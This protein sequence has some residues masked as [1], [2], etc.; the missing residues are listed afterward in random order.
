ML[1]FMSLFA[2]ASITTVP[3]D[4][5]TAPQA[6]VWVQQTTSGWSVFS[7]VEVPVDRGCGDL[8]DLEEV[9][10]NGEPAADLSPGR[11]LDGAC[12]APQARADLAPFE[13]EL[14]VEWVAG[15]ATRTLAVE[16]ATGPTNLRLSS[17]ENGIIDA[18]QDIVLS[19]DSPP[20]ME[21]IRVIAQ[22]PDGTVHMF[23]GDSQGT[24]FVISDHPIKGELGR[25]ELNRRD[26]TPAITEC[27][28]DW[29][30][31][32]WDAVWDGPMAIAL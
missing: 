32:L 10:F 29:D 3:L 15:G 13:G 21:A 2:C 11:K 12:E 8:S 24:D 30:C 18:E 7:D 22:G 28:E 27:P 25:L 1:I 31:L 4:A 14:L 9:L 20:S 16:A 19:W 5:L 6:R 23:D 26:W 17:P